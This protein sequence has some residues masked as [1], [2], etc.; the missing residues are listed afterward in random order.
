VVHHSKIKQTQHTREQ[1]SNVTKHSD[2]FATNTFAAVSTDEFKQTSKNSSRAIIY[3]DVN[4][5]L[6]L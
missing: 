6:P 2:C 4:T 3:K 1:F 5:E